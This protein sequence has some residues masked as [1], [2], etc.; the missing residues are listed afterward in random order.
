MLHNIR[1]IR[2]DSRKSEELLSIYLFG[3][4]SERNNSVFS[5]F[6]LLKCTS[7]IRNDHDTWRKFNFD[8]NKITKENYRRL[9]SKC[10]WFESRQETHNNED[11][12]KE[13]SG[14]AIEFATEFVGDSRFRSES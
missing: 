14:I 13:T 4:V 3:I 6:N 5:S 8:R 10:D 9:E 12:N 1:D 2:N 7:N 11:N